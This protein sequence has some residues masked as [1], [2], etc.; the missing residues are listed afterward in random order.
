MDLDAK[1]IHIPENLHK[2]IHAAGDN[3]NWATKWKRWID[4]HPNATTKQVYQQAGRMMDEYGLSGYPI[5]PYKWNI[6]E[7]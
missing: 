5:L 2:Q 1:I 4:A 3:C 7:A 6:Y